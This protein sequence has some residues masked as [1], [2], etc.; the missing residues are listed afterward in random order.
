[1][2]DLISFSIFSI[3]FNKIASLFLTSKYGKKLAL[4]LQLKNLKQKFFSDLREEYR[5]GS[6]CLAC[7]K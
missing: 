6:N 2:R 5:S 3:S 1:M 7:F 4:G